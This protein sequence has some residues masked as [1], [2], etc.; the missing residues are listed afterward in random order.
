MQRT[1]DD[2]ES[3]LDE[4]RDAPRDRGTVDLIV[5]RPSPGE[6]VV[7][8]RADLDTEVGLVG[9]TW[10]IRP[11]RRTGAPDPDAQLNIMSARA[12][13]A[14]AGDREHWAL[15]GDQLFV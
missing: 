4:I 3:A 11:S 9:D 5:S 6:R 12:V 10:S 13:A 1:T 15:A 2:L 7:H 8:E 14:I